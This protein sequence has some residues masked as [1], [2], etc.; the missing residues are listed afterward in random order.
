M[1][2]KDKQGNKSGIKE[3]HVKDGDGNEITLTQESTNTYSFVSDNGTYHLTVS[4]QAD[5]ELETDITVAKIDKTAPT[6]TA[7]LGA[8]ST[9]EST[10]TIDVTATVGDSGVKSYVVYYKENAT[11]AYP[12]TPLE[13]LDSTQLVQTYQAHRNGFYRFEIVNGA[14]EKA[15]AEVEVKDVVASYPIVSI[16]AELNDGRHTPYTSG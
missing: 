16:K 6:I 5:N 9:D 13:T 2:Q 15:N 12:N 3:L 14:G 11:D 4:D 1:G 7:V 8:L 10:Q